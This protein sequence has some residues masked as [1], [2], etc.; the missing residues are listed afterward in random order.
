MEIPDYWAE[1]RLVGEVDGRRRVVR[2]QGWSEQSP[3]EAQAHAEARARL[4]LE[5]LQAGEQV[6]SLEG[7]RVY[8]EDG[9]PIR[10]QVLARTAGMVVTRNQY[11][12]QCLNVA[13]VLFA[14]VD[15]KPSLSPAGEFFWN[16]LQRLTAVG[17]LT[18]ALLQF[19]SR[20][21]GQ[22]CLWLFGTCASVL[23]LSII[24]GLLARGSKAKAAHRRR[25]QM[26]IAMVAGAQ[27]L[28]LALYESTKGFR[29]LA[30]NRT[31]DPVAEETQKLFRAMGT[32]TAYAQLCAL[33]RCFRAR[34]TA[35]PWRIDLQR[36]PSRA[37]WPLTGERLEELKDWVAGYEERAAS[38]AACRHLQDL[39][40]GEVDPRCAQVQGVHDELCRARTDL[41]LA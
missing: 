32:D 14:D 30:L 39:G 22:G 29:V 18:I 10:E 35:K 8:G 7:K 27:G 6:P 15:L 12:A 13:D 33:Q 23:V 31:L 25:T 3:L 38:Y 19:G 26:K 40:E 4:A 41:P 20:S 37:V 21:W 5:A 28:R 24:H 2:R 16:S 17:A 1:A 36:P 9:M 34:L 11:G